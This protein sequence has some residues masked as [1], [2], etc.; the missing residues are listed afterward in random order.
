MGGG[1]LSEQRH[2]MLWCDLLR[3]VVGLA[4]GPDG[5]KCRVLVIKVEECG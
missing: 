4:S 5:R 1:D 2:L 3:D